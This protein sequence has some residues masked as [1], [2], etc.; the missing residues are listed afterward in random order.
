M[1]LCKQTPLAQAL[2]NFSDRTISSKFKKWIKECHQNFDEEIIYELRD[3]EIESNGDKTYYKQIKYANK[4]F[5]KNDKILCKRPKKIGI[6]THIFR[7]ASSESYGCF[8]TINEWNISNIPTETDIPITKVE[9]VLDNTEY[10]HEISLLEKKKPAYIDIVDTPKVQT[11]YKRPP[12][13]VTA[14]YVLKFITVSL[15]SG[16]N[17]TISKP[18]IG[19]NLQILFKNSDKEVL[20]SECFADTPNFGGC[21]CF[22]VSELLHEFSQAG[23]YIFRFKSNSQDLVKIKNFVMLVKPSVFT[24]LESKKKEIIFKLGSKTQ[25]I[26]LV[27]KDDFDNIVKITNQSKVILESSNNDFILN[28][29]FEFIFD[30]DTISIKN[31]SFTSGKISFEK[32]FEKVNI[33]IGFNMKVCEVPCNI[34]PGSLSTIDLSKESKEKIS[35]SIPVNDNL[36][37]LVILLFDQFGNRIY[38]LGED[39][40][41]IASSEHFKKEYKSIINENS[42]FIFNNLKM[43]S[44]LIQETKITIVFKINNCNIELIANIG[45]LPCSL[46]SIPS[47]IVLQPYESQKEFIKSS[48]SKESEIMGIVGSELTFWKLLFYDENDNIS[49]FN[50]LIKVS[51][52][53]EEELIKNGV[54]NLPPINFPNITKKD[55]QMIID[56]FPEESQND[57]LFQHKIK[58]TTI[59]GPPKRFQKTSKNMR[60]ITCG[61]P[62]LLTF[63]LVDSYNNQIDIKGEIENYSN[64]SPKIEIDNENS[65]EYEIKIEESNKNITKRGN[66]RYEDMIIIGPVGI[67]Q[68]KI[69]DEDIEPEYI[70]LEVSHGIEKFMKVNNEKTLEYNILNFK[71]IPSL[72]ITIHDCYGNHIVS[73]SLGELKFKIKASSIQMILSS[74]KDTSLRYEDGAFTIPNMLVWTEKYG[75]NEI[76]LSTKTLPPFIIV[77]NIE[78]NSLPLNIKL[79]KNKFKDQKKYEIGEEIGPFEICLYDEQNKTIKSI[80]EV[81][82]NI[83]PPNEDCKKIIGILSEDGLE[84]ESQYTQV[85]EKK[86]IYKFPES[87]FIFEKTGTYNITFST[88]LSKLDIFN[89]NISNNVDFPLES[90]LKL[91]YD[92]EVEPGV[93][94]RMYI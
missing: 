69:F 44:N 47:K 31:L 13:E 18:N 34:F 22:K 26:E 28:D 2:L 62:F 48:N 21:Y 88:D 54:V 51:W 8:C 82:L 11:L 70:E 7:D 36:P 67:I 39:I 86:I 58:L 56:I 19:M 77:F 16:E 61:E 65:K 94:E 6:I 46:V 38:D 57:V 35:E 59:S 15:F 50:G 9:K 89:F 45:V 79:H 73:E 20:L 17:K 76:I 14:G 80:N 64:L 78:P 41:C 49:L 87:Q 66:W 90:I 42:E 93:P 24:K 5:K 4:I 92:F 52:S 60:K 53:K 84:E 40:A 33:K 71:I 27:Q 32:K 83:K 1:Y 74:G 91:V 55:I 63:Q 12:S 10:K 81:L 30:N 75:R 23:E 43:K 3:N 25:D 29:N 85:E 68:V 37:S 72:K